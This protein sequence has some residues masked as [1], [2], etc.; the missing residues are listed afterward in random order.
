MYDT[1][2]DVVCNKRPATDITQAWQ[3]TDDI[4]D[5]MLYFL[6]NHDEQRLA[7]DFFAGNP[8]RGL[9]ALVVSAMMRPNPFMFYAGQEFGERGM[10]SEGFS[11]RDGRTTIFDYWGVDTLSRRLN[12]MLSYNERIL[13]DTYAKVLN[14]ANVEAALRNG[15]FFDL[16]YANPASDHF[17]PFSNYAF[18]RKH[19][20]EMI[21]V[22][23]NF[24]GA[25]ADIR[26]RIP[27]HA[28][29]FLKIPEKKTTA[30]DL[31]TG[32]KQTLTLTKDFEFGMTVG[33]Y[34]ARVWKM[35]VKK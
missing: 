11:G 14:L 23:A 29:D 13:E 31:M 28:F 19:N 9:P 16:M 33:G 18:L 24:G 21:L 32:D 10:D 22:V 5:H 7:S 20:D 27:A 26:V 30:I 1:L 17:Y 2:R 34:D 35:Y 3:A 12:H 6:E 8:Q 15:K 25:P 4:A